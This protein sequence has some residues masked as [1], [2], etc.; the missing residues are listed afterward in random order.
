MHLDSVLCYHRWY[1]VASGIVSVDL[2]IFLRAEVRWQVKNK[3][4]N[5]LVGTIHRL[6]SVGERIM[7][8]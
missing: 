6:H 2:K 4:D 1:L 7:T 3:R 5:S 8:Y